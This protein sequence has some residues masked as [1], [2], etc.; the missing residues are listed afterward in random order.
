MIWVRRGLTIPLG[1]LLLFL[2]GAAVVILQV[3][4]SFLDPGYYPRELRNADFYEFVMVDVSRSALNEARKINGETLPARFDENPLITLDVATD[5]MVTSLNTALPPEWLQDVVEQVF[6]E[7]G[8]YI[9]GERESFAVTIRAGDEAEAMVE[10][11]KTLLDGADSYSLLFDKFVTPAVDD[12]LLTDRNLGLNITSE[13]L[14]AS[15]RDTVP[16]EWLQEQVEAALDALTPYLVGRTDSFQIR[17]QLTDAA[18]R[19]LEEIKEVLGDNDV[20]DLLYEDVLAPFVRNSIGDI[21]ELPIGV[22]ITE[23]EV[24]LAL[25]KAAP[26]S[27]VQTQAES[28]IDEASPYLVGRA[29]HFSVPISL[30]ENKRLARQVIRDLTSTKLEDAASLLAECTPDQMFG[31]E[32]QSLASLPVCLPPG[33]LSEELQ[34]SLS[35]G[36]SDAVDTHVLD[37]IPD[38]VTFTEATL[39]SALLQSGGK[40][41]VDLLD[42]IRSVVRDGWTYS[43]TDLREDLFDFG[44]DRAV[45]NLANLR[46]GLTDGWTYTDADLR[47]D[48]ASN[49]NESGLEDFDR[50]RNILG[51]ART[52]KL[53]IYVPVL[54]LLVGIGFLGGT[55]WSER[56]AWAA[57]FLVVTAG[58]VFLLAGP[59]Y[60][61]A[62]APGIVETGAA[63]VSSVDLGGHF[64]ETQALLA[65]KLREIAGSAADGFASGVAFKSSLLVVLGLL[66][67]VISLGWG[68]IRE[69]VQRYRY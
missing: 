39:R 22:S 13:Q 64:P 57:G 10:E 62:G 16:P 36:I 4:D 28:V 47:A 48:L 34:V 2:L 15:V 38:R 43:D 5:D 19:A 37:L 54:L 30:T 25:R 6:D 1:I 65:E 26:P 21:V 11:I 35:Q 24:L 7:L 49:G 9:A 50:A 20:Y 3:S 17:I 69:F 53:L 40:K 68:H 58:I 27:W 12:A 33:V 46:E 63:E 23:K 51:W 8:R 61:I 18:E 29:D 56:I 31:I 32:L 44:G 45:R 52:F 60:R 14:A 59:I 42:Q 66:A 41:E 67:A 55:K